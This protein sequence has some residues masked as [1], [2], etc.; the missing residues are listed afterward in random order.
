MFTMEPWR[1]AREAHNGGGALKCK[2]GYGFAIKVEQ[3][4]PDP[5]FTD[6]DFP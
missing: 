5:H 2:V 4:D 3:R 6:A 1:A